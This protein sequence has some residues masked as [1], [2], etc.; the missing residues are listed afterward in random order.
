[1]I[2]ITSIFL[3]I[4]VTFFFLWYWSLNSGL[5]SWAIPLALF[6]DD[7]FQDSVSCTIFLG[8]LWTLILLIF[9]SWVARIIG[10]SHWHLACLFLSVEKLTMHW[11]LASSYKTLTFFS[12]K[13]YVLLLPKVTLSYS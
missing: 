3:K 2:Y 1:L 6:C 4:P 11:P 13:F 5:T 8:W 9:A 10:V 7:F 12:E